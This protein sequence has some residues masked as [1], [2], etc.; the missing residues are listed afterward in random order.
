MNSASGYLSS[1]QMRNYNLPRT[2]AAFIFVQVISPSSSPTNKSLIFFNQIMQ[3]SSQTFDFYWFVIYLKAISTYCIS[4]PGLLEDTKKLKKKLM[5][6][7][8]KL[9]FPPIFSTISNFQW[10]KL[11]LLLQLEI[12]I[13]IKIIACSVFFH[14]KKRYK[15]DM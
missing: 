4:Q 11:L 2:D 15:V 5:C 10:A 7:T 14:I 3:L 6:N 8:Q 1:L 9:W 13:Y 12:F